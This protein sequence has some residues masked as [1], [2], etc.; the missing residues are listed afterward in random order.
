MTEQELTELQKLCDTSNVLF[1]GSDKFRKIIATVR[2]LQDKKCFECE[3]DRN[4][5][6]GFLYAI[7]VNCRDKLID[8]NS[9]LQA[10]TATVRKYREALEWYANPENYFMNQPKNRYD[11]ARKALSEGPFEKYSK[12]LEIV[13]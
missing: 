11:I 7:C 10:A 5:K 3:C 9:E 6:Y 1:I 13:E 4:N 12:E 2:E 8:N